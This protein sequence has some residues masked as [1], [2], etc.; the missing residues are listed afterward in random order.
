MQHPRGR[1][2][3]LGSIEN[4]HAPHI[5]LPDEL[6]LRA[7][8]NAA[9][10]IEIIARRESVLG[11]QRL[12]LHFAPHA[13]ARIEHSLGHEV[14]LPPAQATSTQASIDINIGR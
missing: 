6:V 2:T 7:R 11:D 9:D 10:A 5:A 1:D 8:E 13:G 3:T 4:Q 14:T 12:R